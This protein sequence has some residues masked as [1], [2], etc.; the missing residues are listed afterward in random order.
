M[1]L[2]G[3][4]VL[5]TGAARGFGAALARR[6]S[7]AGAKLAL[8]GLEP[9]ALEA[10]AA[11]LGGPGRAA[12]AY[13]DVTDLESVE[14]AVQSCIG[15]LGGIDVAVANAG[16][17]TTAPIA[18]ADP[19]G[20]QRTM[21]VNVGGVFH[22]IRAT[23]P[24]VT[25]RK[26]YYLVISSLA[27]FA[28]SPVMGAYVASKA[29]VEALADAARLELQPLGVQVGIAYP[30]WA[31]TDLLRDAESDLPS[32]KAGRAAM[33]FPFNQTVTADTVVEALF[34]AIVKRRQRTFVP[35]W[36]GIMGWTRMVIS[37]KLGD[38]IQGRSS[39]QMVTESQREVAA[40]GHTLSARYRTKSEA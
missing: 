31:D 25:E 27:A 32:F 14:A 20:F 34:Q 4:V 17:L 11:E 35:G 24:A 9:E 1:E 12:W 38:L 36:V 37:S 18:T 7:A 10:L 15:E 28:H 30:G 26:G 5:I 8:I 16:I 3:R 39:R 33:P 21:D 6:C 13:A 23:L 40:L 2:N 19:E 29:G 22:T